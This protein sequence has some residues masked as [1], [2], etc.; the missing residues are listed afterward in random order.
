[1]IRLA[2]LLAVLAALQFGVLPA[3]ASWRMNAYL[4]GA[5]AAT[6]TFLQCAQDTT[7]ATTYDFTSQNTGTASATRWTAYTIHSEDGASTFAVS[8][9]SVDGDAATEVVDFS[10]GTNLAAIYILANSAGT[11]ETV[12]VTMSEAVTSVSICLWQID[13]LQ[14]GTATDTAS[15]AGSGSAPTNIDVNADGI[16]IGGCTN[17]SSGAGYT[18]TGFTERFDG[19]AAEHGATAADYDED[20]TASVAMSIDC[21]RTGNVVLAAAAFR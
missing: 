2:R 18:W 17:G 9:S 11:S 7:D 14:S 12:S 8:S 4:F 20:S 16:A 15:A 6:V 5:P 3:S 19:G 10:S 13:N 1:M 21:Q